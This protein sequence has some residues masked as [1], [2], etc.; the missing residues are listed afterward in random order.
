M[1][2]YARLLLDELMGPNRNSR[3]YKAPKHFYDED[4]CPH[5][6][7]AFCPNDLFFNTKSD[8]GARVSSSL[9]ISIGPCV[10]LHDEKLR[11]EFETSP[12]KDKYK[13][14]EQFFGYVQKLVRDLDSRIRRS[15]DR[16][17]YRGDEIV[18]HF[19]S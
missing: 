10:K 19:W 5:F 4:V 18:S 15:R 13:F 11:I 1:T 3:D 16:L 17:K 8:L 12:D 14:E 6:L 7:A 2:S 9:L